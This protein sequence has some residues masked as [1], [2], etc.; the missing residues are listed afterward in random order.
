[1]TTAPF[2]IPVTFRVHLNVNNAGD[3]AY[4][5]FSESHEELADYLRVHG[6]KGQKLE[7]A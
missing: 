4:A 1:M 7:D 5:L 3:A 2:D 6:E